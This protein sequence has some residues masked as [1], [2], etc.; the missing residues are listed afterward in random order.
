MKKLVLI[1]Y[2]SFAYCGLISP[3]NGSV[4]NHIHVLFE[5]EQVPGALNYEL[6]ISEDINFSSTVFEVTDFSLAYIDKNNCITEKDIQ[7]N[8]NYVWSS[9]FR[10]SSAIKPKSENWKD[11]FGIKICKNSKII[12]DENK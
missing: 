11:L 10:G 6:H 4:L 5:W 7:W 2:I 1:L 8:D 12:E 9:G 3:E